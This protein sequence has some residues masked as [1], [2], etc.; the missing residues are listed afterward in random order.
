MNTEENKEYEEMM[1]AYRQKIREYSIPYLLAELFMAKQDVKT[2]AMIED[3]KGIIL[4]LKKE[5][6][7]LYEML[8]KP[9]IIKGM[10]ISELERKKQIAIARE[11]F[12]WAAEIAREERILVALLKTPSK[13]R[14]ARKFPSRQTL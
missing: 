9:D 2:M 10:Y 8:H 7:I 12:E 11:A 3:F 14:E 13:S 1:I 5:H 6:A 4:P